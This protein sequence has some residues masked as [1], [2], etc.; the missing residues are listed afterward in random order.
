MLPKKRFLCVVCHRGIMAVQNM[1][2]EL[3]G[4]KAEAG[5]VKSFRFALGGR[6][7]IYKAAQQ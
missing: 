6:A 5:D 7:F 1:K 3:V 2:L 4:K